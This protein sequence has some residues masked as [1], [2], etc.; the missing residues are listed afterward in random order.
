M[1]DGALMPRWPRLLLAVSISCSVMGCSR[2]QLV[3]ECRELARA[4]NA[5]MT[6]LEALSKTAESPQKFDKLAQGYTALAAE[7]M[8]LPI[9]QGTAAAEV[10]EYAELMKSVAKSCG[11]FSSALRGEGRVDAARRELERL[12]RR[13]KLSSGKLEAFCR[14]P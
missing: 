13:E 7:V 5:R 14:S 11:D 4:V 3:S 10:K 12:T 8:S 9:A 6:D 2:L 1:L